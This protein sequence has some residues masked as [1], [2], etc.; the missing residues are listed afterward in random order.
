MASF[1]KFWIHYYKRDD[2]IETSCAICCHKKVKYDEEAF[3]TFL[4]FPA[5][6]G[7]IKTKMTIAQHSPLLSW[8]KA[9]LAFWILV[10]E[11]IREDVLVLW[12]TSDRSRQCFTKRTFP[13]ESNRIFPALT[14]PLLRMHRMNIYIYAAEWMKQCCNW[15]AGVLLLPSGDTVLFQP[16]FPLPSRRNL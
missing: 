3:Q 6:G 5:T 4:H 12:G 8:R 10:G 2:I 16:L 1:G 11:E 15:K 14:L 13:K 9:I 7:L